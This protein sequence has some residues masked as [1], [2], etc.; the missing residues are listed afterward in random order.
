MKAYANKRR[1]K[2]KKKKK[3]KKNPWNSNVSIAR[4]NFRQRKNGCGIF[5][6]GT[7]AVKRRKIYLRQRAR[8]S[9]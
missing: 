1:K 8:T 2:K 7:S 4:R 6:T 3:K 5:K 9:L